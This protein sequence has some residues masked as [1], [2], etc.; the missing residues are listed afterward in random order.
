VFIDSTKENEKGKWETASYAETF[1]KRNFERYMTERYTLPKKVMIGEFE[2]SDRQ[3]VLLGEEK[4]AMQKLSFDTDLVDEVFQSLKDEAEEI[5]E[6]KYNE[7][8]AS[9]SFFARKQPEEVEPSK[10]SSSAISE[11]QS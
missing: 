9:S 11:E 3:L 1:D 5:E 6:T 7:S 2:L 10:S 4:E 8:K